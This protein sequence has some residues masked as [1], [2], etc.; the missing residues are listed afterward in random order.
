MKK[1]VFIGLLL[2]VFCPGIWAQKNIFPIDSLEYSVPIER[3]VLQRYEET[4][5]GPDVHFHT[6]FRPWTATELRKGNPV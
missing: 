4:L 3:T 5:S 1:I 6:A 2:L